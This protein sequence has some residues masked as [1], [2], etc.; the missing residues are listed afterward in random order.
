[1]IIENFLVF[2]ISYLL[3]SVP[4][5]LLLTKYIL[6]KD[7]R[8]IGSS[9]IGATNVLR[10]GNKA[11]AGFTLFLDI[12]KGTLPVVFILYY[13]QDLI[14]L[15]GLAAFLGHIFPIWLNFKGGKGVATYLGII[16]IFSYK[17]GILFCITWLLIIFITRYS[18]LASIIS[19]LIIFL[20]SLVNSN[21]GLTSFLFITY[22]SII[23]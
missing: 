4:F 22:F 5:G 17:F 9:N 19:S 21:F 1:M 14:Y 7:I 13:N 10:T 12:A 6:K 11:V 16:F 2:L 15:S 18:S 23:F 8:K 20:V 3:G